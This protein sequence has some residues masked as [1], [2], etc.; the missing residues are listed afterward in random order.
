MYITGRYIR[1]TDLREQIMTR[2]DEGIGVHA[3]TWQNYNI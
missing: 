3:S 1:F 2:M